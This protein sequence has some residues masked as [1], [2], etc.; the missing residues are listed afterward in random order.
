MQIFK[1]INKKKGQN[2]IEFVFIFPILLFSTLVIFE[3]ALFWQDVN[4]VYNLNSEINA[5]IALLDSTG[6]AL[7]DKCEAAQKAK[8]YLEKKD[9]MIT[10][11]SHKYTESVLDG[12]EPFA[13]YKFSSA[14]IK[15]ETK[16]QVTLWVDC[17]N[18]FE[19]GITTQIEFY[20]KTLIIKASI[21]TLS[22]QVIDVIPEK[23]YI[24]SP[25]ENTLRRY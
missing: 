20:H 17:R 12:A 21:P 24:A 22:G 6:Y 9:D 7:G 13:Y 25:K 23:I 14:P 16:P 8:E 10:M 1:R 15:G 18:P 2:L 3:A 11:V 5:N 4:A 19:D